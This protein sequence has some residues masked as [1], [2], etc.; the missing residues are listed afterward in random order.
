[1]K[2]LRFGLLA[3]GACAGTASSVLTTTDVPGA[4]G[5]L[6]PGAIG[7]AVGGTMACALNADG[8]M[9]CWGDDTYNHTRAL[10]GTF[11]QITA[12][13]SY[14]CGLRTDGTVACSRDDELPPPGRFA[15]ISAGPADSTCGLRFDGTSAC[16]FHDLYDKMIPASETFVTISNGKEF[17][18][19]L[20]SD[21]SAS[22][23]G[24]HPQ[25][26]PTPAGSFA[27]IDALSMCAIKP[28]GDIM[29]WGHND[30]WPTPPAAQFK[31]VNNECGLEQDGS[32]VCWGYISEYATEL[33]GRMRGRYDEL[34]VAQYYQG[35][36]VPLANLCTLTEDGDVQCVGSQVPDAVP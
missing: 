32:L 14:V 9:E 19:G 25:P 23:W 4:S 15:Q 2:F 17:G 6:H 34:S 12:A 22:C 26:P 3:L 36:D 31:A 33:V 30:F 13:A 27:A 7:I 10:E 21:G 28:D 5:T 24:S 16:W 1:M 8:T 29:C 11:T 18:C 20:H 35:S